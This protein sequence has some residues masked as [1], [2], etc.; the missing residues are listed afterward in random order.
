M[1]STSGVI[2]SIRKS[3]SEAVDG[4]IIEATMLLANQF[5]KLV[6]YLSDAH[7]SEL[8][9]RWINSSDLNWNDDNWGNWMKARQL[10]E[11]EKYGE[12]AEV[13]NGSFVLVID[14]YSKFRDNP[15]AFSVF[16]NICVMDVT[17]NNT[18]RS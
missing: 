14:N 9:T 2:E 15:V 7:D 13:I 18:C 3:R 6:L 11:E 5:P 1:G 4:K 16:Q 17:R 8:N 12:A 10:I